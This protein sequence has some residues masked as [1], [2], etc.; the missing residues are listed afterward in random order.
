[1]SVCTFLPGGLLRPGALIFSV[2]FIQAIA[3]QKNI[4]LVNIVK[5][6]QADR[7]TKKGGG[8]YKN[9]P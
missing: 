5:Q 1:M 3:R 8:E 9:I 4:C 2:H 7:N 6:T